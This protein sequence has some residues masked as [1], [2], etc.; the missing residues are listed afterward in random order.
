MRNT[1]LSRVFIGP[2]GL[3]SGWGLLLYIFIFAICLFIANVFANVSPV[4]VAAR[5]QAHAAM[6][7]IEAMR[8]GSMLIL[9]GSSLTVVLLVSWI[10][11]RIERR[12]LGV[13]GLGGSHPIRNFAKGLLSG[14]VLISLLV[15]LLWMCRLLVFDR[16]EQTGGRMV[17]FGF[18]WFLVFFLVGLGEGYL[19]LGYLQYTLTR[20]FSAW[21]PKG[22]R[23]RIFRAF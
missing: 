13:Y 16:V 5:K 4:F 1:W 19:S 15:G 9:Y 7:G 6:L 18:K 3:R 22:N 11:A 17:S 10:M 20:A 14:L 12:R 2:D 21:A 8:P 23:L